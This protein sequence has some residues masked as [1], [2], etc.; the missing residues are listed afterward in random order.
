MKWLGRFLVRRLQPQVGEESQRQ[1]G[2]EESNQ[3]WEVV[4]EQRHLQA[5]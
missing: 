3:H 5:Y 4:V 1:E 2:E